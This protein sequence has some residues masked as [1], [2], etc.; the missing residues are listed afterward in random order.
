M[1]WKYGVVNVSQREEVKLKKAKKNP[2][3]ANGREGV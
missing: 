2:S 1:L 3:T